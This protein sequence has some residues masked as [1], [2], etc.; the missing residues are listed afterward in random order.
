MKYRIIAAVLVVGAVVSVDAS[1]AA[2]TKP[3]TPRVSSSTSRR[4]DVRLC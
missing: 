1:I 3:T 4:S 2:D